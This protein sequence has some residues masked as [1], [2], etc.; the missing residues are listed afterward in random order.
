MRSGLQASRKSGPH[1]PDCAHVAS[2]PDYRQPINQPRYP[3]MQ[4]ATFRL[5]DSTVP[6][7]F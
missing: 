2:L 7:A 6:L 5:E 3:L 1:T 4:K